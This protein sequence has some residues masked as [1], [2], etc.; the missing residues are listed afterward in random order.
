MGLFDGVLGGVLGAGAVALVTKYVNQHGGLQGVV[1]QFQ[2]Q[3]L[4]GIVNSWIGTGDNQTVTAEQITK[5]VGA[6]KIQEMAKEAGV[7]PAVLADQL[8]QHLPTAIDKVTP[9]G[10]LPDVAAAATAAIPTAPKL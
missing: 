9:D 1:D 10:K 8:A 5:T 3:G 7:E 2:K 6:D 4:G